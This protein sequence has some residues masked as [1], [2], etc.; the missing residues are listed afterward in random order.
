MLEYA[1]QQ[2][3]RVGSHVGVKQCAM[4]VVSFTA[5]EQQPI[6]HL[7]KRLTSAGEKLCEQDPGANVTL[8]SVGAAAPLD[9][10]GS[11]ELI[12]EEISLVPV[13]VGHDR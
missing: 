7:V 2:Y 1:L 11:G 3:E 12:V 8:L 4:P 13:S 10:L 9:H 6:A 5:V